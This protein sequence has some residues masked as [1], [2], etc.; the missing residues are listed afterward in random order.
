[1]AISQW[2]EVD[3]FSKLA[4]RMKKKT[5]KTRDK[6]LQLPYANEGKFWLNMV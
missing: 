3:F 5:F 6:S 1:M 2:E 4:F